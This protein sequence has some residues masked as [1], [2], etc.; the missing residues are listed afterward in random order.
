M[1]EVRC[2]KSHWFMCNFQANIKQ[3]Q[4][5]SEAWLKHQLGAFLIAYFKAHKRMLKE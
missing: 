5:Y 4:T 3:Q 2:S 1:N